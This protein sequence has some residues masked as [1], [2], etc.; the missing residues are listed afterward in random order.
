MGYL[1]CPG[2][3]R[4]LRVPDSLSPMELQCP[5]CRHTFRSDGVALDEEAVRPAAEAPASA[6]PAGQ[7]APLLGPDAAGRILSK[8]DE[9]MLRDYGSGSGLLELT[10]EAMSL[11]A[12]G[13]AA[14]QAAPPAAPAAGPSSGETDRQFQ[15]VGTALTLANKLVLAHKTELA[16]TRRHAALGWSLLAATTLAAAA[17]GWW[18]VRQSGLTELER[19][20]A[21]NLSTRLLDANAQLAEHRSGE[22]R[23]TEELAA[24]RTEHRAARTEL[25]AARNECRAVQADL[26]GA[27]EALGERKGAAAALTAMLDAANARIAGLAADVQ[28]LQSELA[29]ARPPDGQRSTTQPASAPAQPSRDAGEAHLTPAR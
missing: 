25:T 28:R 18:A 12:N 13:A 2:C 6:D 27:K 4:R 11:S 17:A 10:R 15:I 24:E 26:A 19:L 8:A 21:T 14:P 9:S 29:A 7:G 5:A 1:N 16:R 20:S 3:A 23:L 22:R